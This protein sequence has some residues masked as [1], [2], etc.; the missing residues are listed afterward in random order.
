MGREL[1]KRVQ[2]WAEQAGVTLT[3]QTQIDIAEEKKPVVKK[4]TA[5][6][7]STKKAAD[8]ETPLKTAVKKLKK[9]AKNKE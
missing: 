9:R 8:K 2:Q 6:T 4:S 7:A 3:L 1:L 5:K